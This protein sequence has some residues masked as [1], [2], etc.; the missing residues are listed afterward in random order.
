MIQ[1]DDKLLTKTTKVANLQ[2]IGMPL[3]K[4]PEEIFEEICKK[5]RF[6]DMKSLMIVSKGF[7]VL[8]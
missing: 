5:L 1:F 3:E 7:G 4:I 2:E 6:S 8:N